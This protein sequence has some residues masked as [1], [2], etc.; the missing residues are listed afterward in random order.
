[1]LK[2]VDVMDIAALSAVM[3]QSSLSEQVSVAILKKAMDTTNENTQAL[4]K[5]LEQSVNPHLGSKVDIKV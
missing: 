2:G 3:S 1:M 4:T 5:M